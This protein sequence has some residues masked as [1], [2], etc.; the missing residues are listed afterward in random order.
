[1]LRQSYGEKW[2]ILLIISRGRKVGDQMVYS[3][4][5]FKKTYFIYLY[6]VTC[7]PSVK[8]CGTLRV[9]ATTLM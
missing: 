8:G 7:F 4:Q 2:S 5:H 1:M 3:L 9:L 6:L